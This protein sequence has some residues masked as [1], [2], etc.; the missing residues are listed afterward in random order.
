MSASASGDF[1]FLKVG[2]SLSN[3]VKFVSGL[4]LKESKML[5]HHLCAQFFHSLSNLS[6]E[7]MNVSSLGIFE[8]V[9]SLRQRLLKILTS[10]LLKGSEWE[11]EA[12]VF[13]LLEEG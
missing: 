13:V 11:A 3:Q 6:V 9:H 4:F 10:S 7:S 1:A 5:S 8:P 2:D 12:H